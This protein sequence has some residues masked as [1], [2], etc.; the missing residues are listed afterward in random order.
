MISLSQFKII[1]RIVTLS[2]LWTKEDR[3]RWRYTV[4]RDRDA[5]FPD[6][7]SSTVIV[8]ELNQPFVSI[9]T[10]SNWS[11]LPLKNSCEG[12]Y[13]DVRIASGSKANR[14]NVYPRPRLLLA[15]SGQRYCH[16][17]GQYSVMPPIFGWNSN[18]NIYR[19]K[20]HAIDELQVMIEKIYIRSTFFSSVY[21]EYEI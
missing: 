18:D 1:H 3:Y 10:V 20:G 16:L 7:L 8:V 9:T 13:S 12:L 17:L 4:R 15:R 11:L 21:C 19:Q 14:K 2:L 6:T 5:N